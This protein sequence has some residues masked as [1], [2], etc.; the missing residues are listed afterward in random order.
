MEPDT[1]R[2]PRTSKKFQHGL[3]LVLTVIWLGGTSF[4]LEQMDTGWLGP[5]ILL[6][7]VVVLEV[8]F[9]VWNEGHLSRTK[10]PAQVD[11]PPG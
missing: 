8:A 4:L 5:V 9:V 2:Y 1:P 6:V 11:P 3:E 10:K 7:A